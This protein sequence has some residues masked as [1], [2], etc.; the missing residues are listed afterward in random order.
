MRFGFPGLDN[1]RTLDDYVLSYDK[2][3][4]TA[5]CAVC[6]LGGLAFNTV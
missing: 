1:V 2:R 4:R 3:N 5:H 6:G